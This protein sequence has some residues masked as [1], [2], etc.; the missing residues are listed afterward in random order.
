SNLS[1]HSHDILDV[2]RHSRLFSPC[3]LDFRVDSD[4]IGAADMIKSIRTIVKIALIL[5]VVALVLDLHYK[6]KSSRQY[7]KEYG[8][9]AFQYL[10]QVYKNLVGKD[11]EELTPKSL[12]DL[13]NKVKSLTEDPDKK[14]VSP[15]SDFTTP[16]K[17]EISKLSPPS[18][19]PVPAN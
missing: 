4:H 13:P 17:E 16:A 15:P 7:A 6:G 10:H 1:R 11:L 14:N 3:T 2:Q 9:K 12:S 19:A 8:Q 5:V 18:A